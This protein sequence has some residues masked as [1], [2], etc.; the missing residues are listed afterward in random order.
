VALGV[1]LDTLVVR[2]LL[3]PT[4]AVDLGARIW[5]PGRP[6]REPAGS[7]QELTD[8]RDDLSPVQLNVGH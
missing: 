6:G 2:T 7:R 5:W 4:I 1:L 8:A 3:I